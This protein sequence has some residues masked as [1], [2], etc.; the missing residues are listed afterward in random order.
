M[1]ITKSIYNE[2]FGVALAADDAPMT[3]KIQWENDARNEIAKAEVAKYAF[4]GSEKQVAW[5]EKIVKSF[6]YK[7]LCE[8]YLYIVDYVKALRAACETHKDSQ[9]WISN[10]EKSLSN[11][12]PEVEKEV[13][14]IAENLSGKEAEYNFVLSRV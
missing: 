6:F 4:E 9:Y 2:I 13:D 7:A 10:R 12:F 14:T 5:V 3:E 11:L 8:D 1:N